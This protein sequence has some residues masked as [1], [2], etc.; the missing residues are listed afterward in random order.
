MHA[1]IKDYMYLTKN[2]AANCM[3]RRCVETKYESFK[4][5]TISKIPE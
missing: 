3:K 5:E 4:L 2:G 1:Y